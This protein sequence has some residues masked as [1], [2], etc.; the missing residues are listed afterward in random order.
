MAGNN[1]RTLDMPDENF[2]ETLLP[3]YNG[4]YV[5]VRVGPGGR[6]YKVSRPL[7]CKHS[8]YF[9]AMFES[10]FKESH[11]QAVTMHEIE[12]VVSERS[13][14]MLIQW[15]YLGRL[16]FQSQGPEDS[17]TVFIEL[18]RLAD[19]C[20][21]KGLEQLLADKIKATIVNAIPRC[22]QTYIGGDDAKIRHLTL[23]HI[24][25]ASMLM[26]GH[27]V[28]AIIAEAS[29]G[30]F[31]LMDDFKFAEE[32]RGIANYTDDLLEELRQIIRGHMQEQSIISPYRL[33]YWRDDGL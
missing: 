9:R 15:L 33:A 1:K 27:P 4:P 22:H 12:G 13:F 2:T 8:S 3:L 14:D 11:E 7:L 26:K 30:A 16:H 21:I 29:A 31:I 20:N 25:W 10:G 23:E 24:E 17:I 6:E 19:M 18:A 28:R 5:T 32:L